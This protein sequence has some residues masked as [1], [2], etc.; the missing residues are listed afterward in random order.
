MRCATMDDVQPW[1]DAGL[2]IVGLAWKR[3]RFAG[4]TATPG[5]LT[6]EGIAMVKA[7][8]AA[9]IIH[10]T[11]HLAEESFWQLLELASGPVMASHSNCR[12]YVPTDRQLSDPMIK[13]LIARGGVIGMNFYD[14]FL[15][16]PEE[17]GSRRATL[18]DLIRHIRHIADLAGNA[19]HVA[20]GTDMDGGLGR[21]QIPQEI[22]TSADLPKIADTLSD[23]GFGDDDVANIMGG[24]WLRFFRHHLPASPAA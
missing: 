12:A 9:R 24:N 23:A 1:F 19:N 2:R 13:A 5:P 10:D 21:D 17:Y 3:T 14:K 15:L 16:A 6:D 18:A 7:L 11:S 4:G 20:I 22:Q 8:D